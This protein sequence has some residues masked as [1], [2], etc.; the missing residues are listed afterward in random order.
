[1]EATSN[2]DYSF[3]A[4]SIEQNINR[5]EKH[6]GLNVCNTTESFHVPKTTRE[7]RHKRKHE[8]K[9]LWGSLALQE[10]SKP[11]S[12]R[13]MFPRNRNDNKKILNESKQGFDLTI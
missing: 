2:S 3:T 11:R 13:I 10:I 7:K 1:M 6:R 12:F 4:M 5:N 9:N 8:K